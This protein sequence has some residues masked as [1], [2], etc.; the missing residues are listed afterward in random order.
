VCSAHLCCLELIELGTHEV[1]NKGA[2]YCDIE[3]KLIPLKPDR[4][5]ISLSCYLM[6]TEFY[7]FQAAQMRRTHP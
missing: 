5:I 2:I 4:F 1:W 6:S 7:Q 3:Q